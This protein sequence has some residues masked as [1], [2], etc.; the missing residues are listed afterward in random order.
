MS[1][2]GPLILIV[3]DDASLGPLMIKVLGREKCH[4]LLAANAAE[5]R[6]LWSE[7]R[8]QVD[9]LIT[10]IAL[11]DGTRGDQLASEFRKERD[12]LPIIFASGDVPEIESTA[13][14]KSLTHLMKPFSSIELI[15]AVRN[16][17]NAV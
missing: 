9:L 1:P 14:V 11:S 4:A 16:A 17:L 15:G 12:S 8:D 10:D 6:A 3:E 5:A 7:H 2:E 13:D